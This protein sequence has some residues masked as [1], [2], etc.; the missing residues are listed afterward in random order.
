MIH[1]RAVEANR[2]GVRIT[3]ERGDI[4]RHAADAIV[5]AANT[6][7][8]P[9][10]GVCGAIHRTGGPA[11][12]AECTRIRAERGRCPTGSAVATGAGDL[13]AKRVLHAVGP[14]WRGGGEGEADLLASAY[15]AC[16]E[17]ADA[18]GLA[19]V[20]FPSISTG[21]Y[22]YPV[23]L[24]AAAAVGAVC[25]WIDARRRTSLGR[26]TWVLFDAATLDAYVRSLA[27]L[28]A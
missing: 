19:S 17:I 5:N 8:R 1:G 22:G 2:R 27:R 10:A 21:I 6:D 9:G 16:L 4:T 23:D 18:E 11:I 3:L 15:R 13:P 7:L 20:A 25:A 12:E 28:E 26:V 14:V 24:A